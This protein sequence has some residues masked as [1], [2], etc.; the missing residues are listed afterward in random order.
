MKNSR[1]KQKLRPTSS[2][3]KGALFNMLG[4]IEGLSFLDLFAG[5]GQVGLEACKRGAKVTFVEKNRTLAEKIKHLS[6]GQVVCMDAIRFLETSESYYDIIFAD[7][8]YSFES[9]DKLIHLALKKLKNG[10]IF[11][12]EHSKKLNF[13]ADK[14]KTYGDTVLS[15]WRKEDG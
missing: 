7:P 15:L 10:G 12:L 9:Y 2:L 1:G 6:C 5:T 8:P 4:D 14:M 3:V 11:V 13:G